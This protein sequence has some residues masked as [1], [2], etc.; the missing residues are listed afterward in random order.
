MG[1][2]RSLEF[3]RALSDCL[4]DFEGFT[5]LF[6]EISGILRVLLLCMI[7]PLN[8]SKHVM[9]RQVLPLG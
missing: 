7:I 8:S 4:V 2:N 6:P 1:R 5:V 3:S 9:D